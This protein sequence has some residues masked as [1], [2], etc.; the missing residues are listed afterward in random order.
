MS[1]IEAN[2][3]R[4]D[5]PKLKHHIGVLLQEQSRHKEALEWYHKALELGWND[6]ATLHNISDAHNE[7]GAYDLAL[8]YVEQAL[9]LNPQNTNSVN[10]ALKFNAENLRLDLEWNST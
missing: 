6:S 2:K 3:I 9:L 8:R 10:L 4:D 5:E 1:Y 7:Q